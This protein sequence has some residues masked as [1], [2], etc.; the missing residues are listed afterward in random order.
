MA[1]SVRQKI[2][3]AKKSGPDFARFLRYVAP[4]DAN[5]CECWTGALRGDGY[6]LFRVGSRVD[7]SRRMVSAHR[8][9]YERL[10]GPVPAGKEL[11]HSCHN[12]RCVR[13]VRPLSHEENIA[14]MWDAGR[15]WSQAAAT[16]RRILGREA[17]A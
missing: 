4:P 11:A 7:G 10:R 3:A 8:W 13:H 5:G 12:R 16:K 1:L 6:G 17:V 15:A 2:A 14:E 9:L